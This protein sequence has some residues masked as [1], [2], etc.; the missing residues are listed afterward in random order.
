MGFRMEDKEQGVS[1]DD[2]LEKT[3]PV[4]VQSSPSPVADPSDS[5]PATDF[6]KPL[7]G[8]GKRVLIAII[9]VLLLVGSALIGSF[10]TRKSIKTT[11]TIVV[12]TQS[13]DNGTLNK[14]TKQLGGGQVNQQLTISPDTLF[15]SNVNV[16]GS[17]AA[18]GNL[19]VKGTSNLQGDVTT[20]SNLAVNGGLTVTSGASIGGNLTVDGK[21]TA[22]SLSVG[23]ITLSTLSLTGNLS[24]GG[25]LITTG[26]APSITASVSAANGTASISGNDISGTINITTG[27]GSAIA[28]EIAIITFHNPFQLAPRVML[29]P[30]NSDA[31]S[32]E[33]YVTEHSTFFTI[34]TAA[35]PA[36]STIYSFNYFV[37]Q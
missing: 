28:G 19:A 1:G 18:N 27:K 2:S 17:L 7:F 31:A 36:N 6:K 21:I 3:T 4:S 14:L 11:K 15:K 34:R 20:G 29:T 13:L 9:I 25:H 30:L 24:V 22:S 16:Q 8:L 32:V 37:A 5:T 23:S 35:T 12:N 10:I 33:A 26:L